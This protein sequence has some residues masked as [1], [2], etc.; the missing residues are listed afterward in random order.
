MTG[1]AQATGFGFSGG[2]WKAQW[3]MAVDV[4]CAVEHSLRGWVWVVERPV[5]YGC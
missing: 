5:V 2:S 1:V 3:F 4:G